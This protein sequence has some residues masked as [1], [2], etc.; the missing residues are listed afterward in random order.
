MVKISTVANVPIMDWGL[1]GE[2]DKQV[3]TD[4][5]KK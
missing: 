4:I 1:L 5:I 2:K 3:R